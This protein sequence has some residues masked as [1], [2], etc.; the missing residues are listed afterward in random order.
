MKPCMSSPYLCHFKYISLTS[1]Y[2][3]WQ[4]LLVGAHRYSLSLFPCGTLF[5]NEFN[6]PKEENFFAII[7]IR[8]R[9][10]NYHWI[11]WQGHWWSSEGHSSP[12]PRLVSTFPGRK[13]YLRTTSASNILD[14]MIIFFF[15]LSISTCKGIRYRLLLAQIFLCECLSKVTP[16]GVSE[17]SSSWEDCPNVSRMLA[18]CWM[19]HQ[20]SLT[21]G[22]TQH[23]T[24]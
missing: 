6:Y 13:L 23:H 8:K 11:I 17:F 5:E 2:V 1:S 9:I 22:S 3:L 21:A 16:P 14:F 15:S 12:G 7:G 24:R 19:C 4:N 18:R 20:S 10:S